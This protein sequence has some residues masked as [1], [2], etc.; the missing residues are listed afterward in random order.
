MA[1]QP[2]AVG[3]AG[4]ASRIAEGGH[5]PRQ[6]CLLFGL[7]IVL[8]NQ[9]LPGYVGA[10][11]FGDLRV[12]LLKTSRQ[13]V[14]PADSSSLDSVD[15]DNE[16]VRHNF[17]E[18]VFVVVP[19]QQHAAS[20]ALRKYLADHDADPM[21]ALESRLRESARLEKRLNDDAVHASCGQVVT[22]GQSIQLLHVN[23]S[24]FVAVRPRMLSDTE[25]DAM[26]VELLAE[27]FEDA[28]FQIQSP[29]RHL[30]PGDEV[31]LHDDVVFASGTWQVQLHV[32]YRLSMAQHAA[33]GGSDFV[34]VN[35]SAS[36][37]AFYIQRFAHIDAPTHCLRG[38]DLVRFLHCRVGTFLSS[39]GDAVR[40]CHQSSDEGGGFH[41]VQSLWQVQHVDLLNGNE[42]AVSNVCCIRHVATRQF[43]VVQDING[44]PTCTLTPHRTSRSHFTLATES[45]LSGRLLRHDR[46]LFLQ[47]V[48][49]GG[50]IGLPPGAT[51]PTAA[52]V[53]NAATSV[54]KS[55]AFR[56]QIIQPS[57]ATESL[58]LLS[59]L[60]Q[61]QGVHDELGRLVHQNGADPHNLRSSTLWIVHILDELSRFCIDTRDDRGAPIAARQNVLVEMDCIG[62]VVRLLQQPFVDWAG[63]LSMAVF[64][65]AADGDAPPSS[66]TSSDLCSSIRTIC[67][68]SY[69][70]LV[71]LVR[72]NSKTSI[73]CAAHLGTFGRQVGFD[74]HAEALVLE[75][76]C[77]S[78]SLVTAISDNVVTLFVTLLRERGRQADYVDYL[79][80]LCQFKATG[81]QAKQVA[82]C[83]HLF[84]TTAATVAEVG[85]LLDVHVT[86]NHQL[87]VCHPSTNEWTP[88]AQLVAADKGLARYFLATIRMLSAMCCSRNYIA[89]H[90]VEKQFPRDAV[91]AVV[92]DSRVHTKMRA[93][94]CRLLAAVYV[95]RLPHEV[96]PRPKRVFVSPTVKMPPGTEASVP[97]P[98]STDRNDADGF[99][100]ALKTVLNETLAACQGTLTASQSHLLLGMLPLCIQMLSFGCYTDESELKT[101]VQAL[102]PL[103][104]DHMQTKP[105]PITS[106]SPLARL[107]NTSLRPT[108]LPSSI[109]DRPAAPTTST[110]SQTCASGPASTAQIRKASISEQAQTPRKQ[111][112]IHK[113]KL[114]LCQILT[115]TLRLSMDA[116]LD[117]I[118]S[119]FFTQSFVR[120]DA[121]GVSPAKV[122]AELEAKWMANH[123]AIGTSCESIL[124]GATLFDRL[125]HGHDWTAALLTLVAS[126]YPALVSTALDLLGSSFN[127]HREL[128][129]HLEH[130]IVVPSDHAYSMYT[131]MRVSASVLRLYEE[132]SETWLSM[133]AGETWKD[134]LSSLEWFIDVLATT[135]DLTQIQEL[136]RG[137]GVDD[138][139]V[140]ITRSLGNF[141]VATPRTASNRVFLRRQE[142]LLDG[143]YRFFVLYTWQNTPAQTKLHDHVDFFK[144][145]VS[146]RHMPVAIFYAIYH[147]NVALCRAL[148]PWLVPFVV[149]LIDQTGPVAEYVDIL[150]ALAVC[151]GVPMKDNQ[152]A[153][154]L[155]LLASHRKPHVVDSALDLSAVTN[156]SD[157]VAALD[158]LL[159]PPKTDMLRVPRK[160]LFD[161]DDSVT[162]GAADRQPSR[163]HSIQERILSLVGRFATV[164]GDDASTRLPTLTAVPFVLTQKATTHGVAQTFGTIEASP[165]PVLYQ[166]KLLELL[167]NLTLGANFVCEARLQGLI[168]LD[169]LVRAL[170][171]KGLPL[172]LKCKLVKVLHEGWLHTEQF[173]AEVAGSH[174]LVQ[175]IACQPSILRAMVQRARSSDESHSTSHEALFVLDSLLPMLVH[176]FR[177][178]CDGEVKHDLVGPLKDL[179]DIF[180]SVV[181]TTPPRHPWLGNMT[182]AT[183]DAIHA[184]VDVASTLLRQ[185]RMALPA[186]STSTLA[187]SRGSGG[188]SEAQSALKAFAKWLHV[189]PFYVAAIDRDKR[190]MLDAF[191][192]TNTADPPRRTTISARLSVVRVHPTKK[193]SSAPPGIDAKYLVA[194]LIAHANNSEIRLGQPAHHST[195][196]ILTILEQVSSSNATQAL[197]HLL[198]APK[199]MVELG[200]R[201]HDHDV[202]T[203]KALVLLAMSLLRHGGFD[204]QEQFFALL[205][206][207]ANVK[208]F[209]RVGKYLRAAIAAVDTRHPSEGQQDLDRN[210]GTTNLLEMLRLLCEGHHSKFQN[211]LRHQPCSHPS[212]NVVELVV[213]LFNELVRT[214]TP[215]S[216][217]VLLKTFQAIVEFIQGP[218][219]GNQLAVI[220]PSELHGG[221]FLDS[222]NVLLSLSNAEPGFAPGDVHRLKYMCS[223]AL[224]ALVEGRT[225]TIIHDRMA[226]LLSMRLLKE[227]LVAVYTSFAKRHEGRYTEAAFDPDLLSAEGRQRDNY[228]VRLIKITLGQ[229]HIPPADA[230]PATSASPSAATSTTERADDTGFPRNPLLG[231][232]LPGPTSPPMQ[233]MLN[234]GFNIYILFHR[235]L[236][237][238]AVAHILRSSL[239]PSDGDLRDLEESPLALMNPIVAAFNARRR[240]QRLSQLVKSD[241]DVSYVEAYAFFHRYCASVEVHV[242]GDKSGDVPVIPGNNLKSA[243]TDGRPRRRLQRFYF[244]K[245]PVCAFLTSDMRN[246]VMDNINRDSPAEKIQDLF[247]RSDAIIAEMTHRYLMSFAGDKLFTWGKLLSFG[248]AIVLNMLLIACYVDMGDPR[249]ESLALAFQSPDDA[250]YHIGCVGAIGGVPITSIIRVFGL[251]Q[252]I[253]SVGIVLLY[254]FTYGPLIMLEGWK[255]HAGK[256]KKAVA[257]TSASLLHEAG[258]PFR[259]PSSQSIAALGATSP[260]ATAYSLTIGGVHFENVRPA[261]IGRSLVFLLLN[262]VFPELTIIVHAVAWPWKSLVLS[263]CLMMIAIY[264]FAIVGFTYF[265]H[266]YPT[267]ASSAA[268]STDTI[269]ECGMLL[270]CY[271]TTF[272]QTFKNNGGIGSYMAT[273]TPDDIMN[274]GPRLVFDNLFNIVIL[275][276][277]VNIFFGIIIDTFGDQRSR[278]EARANDIAGKCFVCSLS[279]ETFDR[280][281][282]LGFEHHI[283]N[284]HNLWNY[285]FLVAHLRFKSENEFDGV[286]QYLW[287]C[288]RYEDYSF[289]PLYHALALKHDASV[290]HDSA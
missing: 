97:N 51:D 290:K 105:I 163:I 196:E 243:T 60:P 286:E 112:S 284:E 281:A 142:H 199:M 144:H 256:A 98:V 152:N 182:A 141:L 107:R 168:P 240:L 162:Q 184:F 10:E 239:I 87:T 175:F 22:Y 14:R 233:F 83:G 26:K 166:A 154:S 260:S 219:E 17:N 110:S 94:F 230:T 217:P 122:Y 140:N 267:V 179:V 75:L 202:A 120:T 42:V 158:T 178:H 123:A 49:T 222:I 223:L 41:S 70:L 287:R 190:V 33:G 76:L 180:S 153:I 221:T 238:P 280:V 268:N 27:P 15:V 71:H 99:F 63:P 225:D 205:S 279:R 80:K 186:P 46:P 62:L 266:Q 192:H 45:F 207:G 211:L 157:G 58:F 8:Y 124:C 111:H 103:L 271:L 127:V 250:Y 129:K 72:L 215:T 241:R 176:Y 20:T 74:V 264:I 187:A 56:L 30:C 25:R 232:L 220:D 104:R 137:L 156:D 134:V 193:G 278:M 3:S 183:V 6:H 92:Q 116:Q 1:T 55:N 108:P 12:T 101:L 274:W 115:W 24:K 206:M 276:I 203:H 216:V 174:T 198:G 84:P 132:T 247:Q 81:I 90:A 269:A 194:R 135:D 228:V 172:P 177:H 204:A 89:I 227:T 189:A 151:N 77:S 244:P 212:V 249:F 214:L 125:V 66:A 13:H 79:T 150:S 289:V 229:A 251:F 245:P 242:G 273:Q 173:V 201:A 259:S 54:E 224:V 143:C 277:I 170:L 167:A 86:S 285:V 34:E 288:I 237:V 165:R 35:G 65:N 197:V 95:D 130:V 131:N 50:W 261:N 138:L 161:R 164:V 208:W 36:G 118:V 32:G 67:Q 16:L 146:H 61:L 160:A 136:V 139:V 257:S 155:Q 37:D 48:T 117:G 91:V 39:E 106:T 282:P 9:Q 113:C 52:V 53:S 18:R 73:V 188:L 47:H 96:L 210:A 149:D 283:R 11:G 254:A 57:E 102:V 275:L 218:C 234:A 4:T 258:A 69:K 235:L 253:V 119:W 28:H 88:I 213:V 126:D 31:L 263:F 209:D 169:S 270:S 64:C 145:C 82:L 93:A 109:E 262:P 195:L 148:P 59:L 181:Q 29:Y 248:F 2:A 265:R 246:A 100:P 114:L 19:A 23:S 231:A 272:D 236:E 200:C 43:L 121:S 5:D 171:R 159:E 252:V 185:P 40:L 226:T 44:C 78:E 133:R 128:R 191:M 7:P 85:I 68:H 21:S 147:N 38:G 255:R